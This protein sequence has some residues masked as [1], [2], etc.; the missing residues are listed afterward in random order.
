M[1]GGLREGHFVRFWPAGLG[2]HLCTRGGGPQLLMTV[3]TGPGEPLLP[4]DVAC[5][6]RGEDAGGRPWSCRGR[7]VAELQHQPS[8]VSPGGDWAPSEGPDSPWLPRSLPSRGHFRLRCDLL[9]HVSTPVPWESCCSGPAA[10]YTGP[11]PTSPIRNPS[12][13]SDRS[14]R[15]PSQGDGRGPGTPA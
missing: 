9:S 2:V 3:G 14:P 5:P 10:L 6:R 15:S 11:Y 7:K 8:C 12:L 4:G 13:S 1:F